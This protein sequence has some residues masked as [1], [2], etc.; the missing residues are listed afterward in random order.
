MWRQFP[1]AEPVM[2]DTAGT[3]AM[4]FRISRADIDSGF[5]DNAK[6]D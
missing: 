2:P 4:L 5:T 1:A 6:K 3:L